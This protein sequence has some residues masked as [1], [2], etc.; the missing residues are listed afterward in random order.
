MQV[1]TRKLTVMAMLTAVSVILVWLIHL[2]LIPSVPF[3]EY[4]PADI[5]ILIGTFVFGPV[6]GLA[7]TFAASVLQGL[8]VSASGGLYG[9]LMHFIATG[10]MCLVAGSIY[11]AHKTRKVAVIAL[12][13]GILVTTVVMAGA[14]LVVTPLFT[15]WP[16]SAVK[17]LLL[18]GIIPFNLV[19]FSVNSLVT[20]L[21]YKMISRLIHKYETMEFHK[22]ASQEL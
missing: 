5:P 15:G 1:K 7:L 2:P 20:F 14:N 16:V 8:T 17:D 21:L 19:K 3:L 18:P 4:D 10:T 6:A 22:K 12:A 13:A 11:R 9:I